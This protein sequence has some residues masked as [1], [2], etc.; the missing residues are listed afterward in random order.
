MPPLIEAVKAY[1]TEGEI[2]A[3][4]ASVYGRYTERAAF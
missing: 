4:M 1:A 3:A 2:V